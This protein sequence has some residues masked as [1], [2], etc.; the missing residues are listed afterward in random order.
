[1]WFVGPEPDDVPLTPWESITAYIAIAA[2][3]VISLIAIAGGTGWIFS[4][5]F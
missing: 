1:M 4:K 3:A 2:A 5:F